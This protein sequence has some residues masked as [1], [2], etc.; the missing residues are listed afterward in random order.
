MKCPFCGYAESKVIDSRPADEGASIRRRRECLAC[1]RRFTTYEVMERLPLVVVK[2]DGRGN[3]NEGY[4]NGRGYRDGKDTDK[5]RSAAGG[6]GN[7]GK[8]Q[9]G[10]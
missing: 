3:G 8:N 5:Y 6:G 9:G 4:R 1:Q 2:R 7:A 10:A